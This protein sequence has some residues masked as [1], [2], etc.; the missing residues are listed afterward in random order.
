MAERATLVAISWDITDGIDA[1]TTQQDSQETTTEPIDV[2][3]KNGG[4][5]GVV[6]VSDFSR[7]TNDVVSTEKPIMTACMVFGV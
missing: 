7:I 2:T 4:K 5:I 1:K 3:V 6:A